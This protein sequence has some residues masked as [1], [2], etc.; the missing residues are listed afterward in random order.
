MS[1]SRQRMIDA[2]RYDNPDRIPV[3]YH[4]SEAGLYVHGQKLLDLLEANPPDNP[5]AFDGIPAPPAD[6]FDERGEYRRRERNEW[7]VVTEHRVFGI[8]GQSVEYPFD[9]WRQAAEEYEFPDVPA[10]GSE[11][12]AADRAGLADAR[13]EFYVISGWFSIFLRLYEMRPMDEVLI[14]L[15]L[16]EPDLLRFLDRLVD[17][18]AGRIEYFLAAG[19][20]AFMFADDWCTQSGM[21]ISPSVFRDIFLPHYRRLT[22]PIHAAGRDVFFHVCGQADAILDDLFDLGVRCLWPQIA[23]YDADAFTR[24]LADRGVSTYIHPDRQRLVPRGAPAEIERR[25]AEHAERHHRLG[26]GGIFY[27]EIENDAP[28]ENVRTLIESIHKYR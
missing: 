20:D 25:I 14:D 6:A 3:V 28:W 21:L 5:I 9:N 8:Q 11:P 4:P 1:D 18:W 19:L 24:R 2:L 7:G 13:R 15:T 12:F 16:G 22:A 17:F 26:G 23:C 27:V 10:I